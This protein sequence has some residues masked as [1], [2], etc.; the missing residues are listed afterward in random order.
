MDKMGSKTLEYITLEE[1]IKE[2]ENP[3][4]SR[5]RIEK[6]FRAEM[7]K[8]PKFH[9]GKHGHKY[10]NY[11]CG[12]CGKTLK[13]DVGENYCWNCGYRVNWDNPRCLTDYQK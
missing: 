8:K 6:M 4:L 10:D 3:E 12:N 11:T 5:P 7:G 9:A 1:C 13:Y 2:Y